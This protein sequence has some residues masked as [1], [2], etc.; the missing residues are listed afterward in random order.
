MPFR[1][2]H[3]G[4]DRG[5]LAKRRAGVARGLGGGER[6]E[7]VQRRPRDAERDA[8][9]RHPVERCQRDPVERTGL[10]P[11]GLVVADEGIGFRD[12]QVVHLV[13]VAAGPL[14]PHRVPDR[15][16]RRRRGGK[17]EGPDAR[18][19]VGDPER[20][21]VGAGLGTMGAVP[22]RVADPAR[23]GP[24]AGQPVA[25]VGRRGALTLV[26]R[27]P[28]EDR[29]RRA[30]HR[31]SHVRC[32][33]CS[34]KR[35]TEPLTETPGGAGIRGGDRL[36]HADYRHRRCLAAP[37][38][39]RQAKPEQLGLVHR[40]HDLG[41]YLAVA[42]DPVGLGR[43]QGGEAARA[44]H[45]VDLARLQRFGSRHGSS[46]AGERGVQP[47]PSSRSSLSATELMQ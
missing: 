1:Q 31:G 12:E 20:H 11:V 47:S 27:P 35:A 28:G 37:H 18:A 43:D 25:A 5:A 22:G 42:L 45:P 30:E 8:R 39:A 33:K 34:G 6:D 44:P 46:I 16:D 2:R 7:L 26:E 40:G 24:A 14:E 9:K 41:R 36:D 3:V 13:V 32:N 21:S 23:I 19:S 10:A 29:I 4:L 38:R 15:I 17:D